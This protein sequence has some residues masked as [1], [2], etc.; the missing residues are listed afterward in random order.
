MSYLDTDDVARCWLADNCEAMPDDLRET[1]PEVFVWP[2]MVDQ[3]YGGSEEGG[4]WFNVH[5]PIPQTNPKKMAAPGWPT[6]PRGT[7]T[8]RL[9]LARQFV[10]RA[11]ALAEYFINDHRPSMTST[12]SEGVVSWVWTFDEPCHYPK[13]RPR[14]E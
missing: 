9:D 2:A 4:W 13:T 8:M 14:Y 10:R 7:R 11:N 1:L 12:N 5:D 3:A 6:A